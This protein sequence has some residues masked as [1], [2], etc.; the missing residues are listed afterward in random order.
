M[1]VTK[2]R[3]SAYFDIPDVSMFLEGNTYTGSENTFNYR[4]SPADDKLTSAVWYGLKCFELSEPV[5]TH[6]EDKT[7]EGLAALVRHIDN[8]YEKYT[9]LVASGEVAPRRTYRAG[10]E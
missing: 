1:A 2:L 3:L 6:E 4:I 9:G 7:E 8:E 5:D 10:M